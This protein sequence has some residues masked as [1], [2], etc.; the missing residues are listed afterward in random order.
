M[1]LIRRFFVKPE[2]L[3]LRH[4]EAEDKTYI[5]QYV[6][7]NPALDGKSVAEVS[8]LSHMHFVIS[9]IWRDRQVLVPQ[10]DT[11]MKLHDNIMVVTNKDDA[12][13]LEMLFGEKSETDWN[14]PIMAFL[15]LALLNS[16]F[17]PSRLMTI[18]LVRWCYVLVL[19]VSR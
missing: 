5:A 10:A 11:M 1:V 4:D 13:T 15:I 3:E 16:S 12:S 7:V 19:F 9:R 2:D 14:A 17:E 18:I 6:V 8:A